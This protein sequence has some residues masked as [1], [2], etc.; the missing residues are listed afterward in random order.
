M[1]KEGEGGG[2][3]R[4]RERERER[5]RSYKEGSEN[6]QLPQNWTLLTTHPLS[7]ST[8]VHVFRCSCIHST[9]K[10][11]T[12]KPNTKHQKPVEQ[13]AQGS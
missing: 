10:K 6:T 9:L 8:H 11:P 3:E 13:F 12:H 4:V 7:T 1:K 2:G 5:E